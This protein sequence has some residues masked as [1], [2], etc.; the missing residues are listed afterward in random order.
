MGYGEEIN[1]FGNDPEDIKTIEDTIRGYFSEK[2]HYLGVEE[3]ILNDLRV[4]RARR[5]SGEAA[6]IWGIINDEKTND[7]FRLLLNRLHRAGFEDWCGKSLAF[8]GRDFY[9]LES[10][11][12]YLWSLLQKSNN[13]YLDLR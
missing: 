13:L 10:L 5:L 3:K 2:G 11:F 9:G 12:R 1:M 7:D 4:S 6:E 8:G